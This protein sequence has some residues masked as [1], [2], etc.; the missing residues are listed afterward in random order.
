MEGKFQYQGHLDHY[1]EEWL[2][3]RGIQPDHGFF[4]DEDKQDSIWIKYSDPQESII[5]NQSPE[6]ETSTMVVVKWPD[7]VETSRDNIDAPLYGGL[8]KKGGDSLVPW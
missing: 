7:K 6:E 5:R 1:L 3:L 2:S 8:Y 4:S